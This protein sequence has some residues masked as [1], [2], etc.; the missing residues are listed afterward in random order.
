MFQGKNSFYKTLCYNFFITFTNLTRPSLARDAS[1]RKP[2]S[3]KSQVTRF[4][5]K[6]AGQLKGLI[7]DLGAGEGSFAHYLPPDAISLDIDLENLKKL[8]GKR[9]LAS[10]ARLPFK[11]DTFDGVWSCAVLEHVAENYIPEAIRVTKIGR[12]IYI[13]TP[14]RN[15]PFDPVKRLLGLGDWTSNPGHVKLYSVKELCQFGRVRGEVYWAPGL[16][17]LA[18]I[19]PA[20][21]HTLMLCVDV[22]KEL[23]DHLQYSSQ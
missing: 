1:N 19:W 11:S 5:I 23:K 6:C 18:R 16:D 17:Q 8:P 21:G 7:L 2:L 10:A 14:N 9:V 4:R 20:L 15:S 13:L 22:T 3:M 12:K